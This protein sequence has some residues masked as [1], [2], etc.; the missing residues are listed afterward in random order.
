MN[1]KSDSSGFRLALPTAIYLVIM[2]IIPL[3]FV[4]LMSVLSRGVNPSDYELPLTIENYEAIFQEPVWGILVRTVRIALTSTL[5]CFIIGYP[6][7]FFIS[8]RQ[9]SWV[10]NLSLF[11]VVLPFWTNFLVRTYAWQIILGR[12]GVLNDVLGRLVDDTPAG[13]S[14]F[15]SSL[16]DFFGIVPPLDILFT[17]TAIIIGLVYA[18][19]PFMVLPIY[20]SA[21]RF[22]FRYVEAA[23]DLGANDLRTF[24]RVVFPLTLPG[25]VAGW[26]LVF[27][28]SLGAFVTPAL[29]GGTRGFMIGTYITRQFNA[30]GGSWTLGSG[31]SII[32]MLMVLL[33][34]LIYSRY[35]GDSSY[36]RQGDGWFSRLRKRLQ[37]QSPHTD[38]NI[39]EDIPDGAASLAHVDMPEPDQR[40][41][42]IS[43]WK[44]RRDLIIRRIGQIGL[45]LNPI[46]SYIFLWLPIIVLIIFSFNDS[47]TRTAS[48]WQG[49]S[50]KW[51]EQIFEG[52]SGTGGSQFSTEQLLDSV[53]TSLQVSITATLI[54]IVM[55]TMVS[56][57]MVRGKF[58]GQKTLDGL[59]YI[60]VVIPDI[61][62][63]VS[64]VVFFK[65]IFDF[66]EMLIGE[67]YFLSIWTVI[68]AHVAF[69]I[70]FVAIVVR[71]RLADMNPRF[72]EASRDLGAN[73]WRTF[74]RVTYPLLLPAIL[75]GGLLAFT[76]SLDDFVVTFFAGGGT[77]TTLTVF[78][79]G[80][81]RRGV[82]PEINAV[83][84]LMILVSITLIGLSSLLQGRNAT[85]G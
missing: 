50:T 44:I 34:L 84:A 7:A 62:M 17:D 27:I 1:K 14:N 8:T 21:E 61:T 54:S 52:I 22:N 19:L 78:V 55:G 35:G 47:T 74:W 60:P 46:F 38:N 51:Y 56:L 11:L 59:L 20:A 2:F 57:A 83:S 73:E 67:R 10:R 29:L 9:Q 82:S 36:Q 71:A 66:A 37:G 39:H 79:W 53:Q 42:E 49:F 80:L 30:A 16:Y 48:I 41:V 68:A 58:R 75:A 77:T 69:N 81:V 65:F 23:Q 70:S 12:R 25:V 32:M 63:G 3:I 4:L 76:L 33:S 72:E 31:L 13:V 6:L 43:E 24:M 18:Y 5:F 15:F 40:P 26:I 28:P 45:G 85:N 64:L